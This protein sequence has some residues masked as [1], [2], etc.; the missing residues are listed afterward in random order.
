MHLQIKSILCKEL[1]FFFPYYIFITYHDLIICKRVEEVKLLNM[2]VLDVLHCIRC[3]SLLY[4][5]I[6]TVF[7]ISDL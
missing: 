3:G 1:L 4:G 5:V 6:N 2:A 7:I